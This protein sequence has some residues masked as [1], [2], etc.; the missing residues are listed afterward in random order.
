MVKHVIEKGESLEKIAKKHKI[1]V[2]NIIDDNKIQ[3]RTRLGI[4]NILNIREAGE[5][6]EKP[7]KIR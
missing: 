4:G 7:K 3:D 5:N 2:Q 1:S 6:I